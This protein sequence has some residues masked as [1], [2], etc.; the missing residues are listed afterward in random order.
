MKISKLS[1]LDRCKIFKDKGFYYKDN[2]VYSH[3]NTPIK[4]RDLVIR[5]KKDKISIYKHYFIWYYIHGNLPSEKL[6]HIDGNLNNNVLENLKVEKFSIHYYKK[7]KYSSKDG[8]RKYSKTTHINITELTKSI[9]IS[10]GKGYLI[11]EAITSII[12]L[13]DNLIRK[14]YHHNY[15]DCYDCKMEGLYHMLKGWK[16]FDYNKYDNAFTYLTELCKRGMAKQMNVLRDIDPYEKIR[17]R[18]ISL[19][20]WSE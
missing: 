9:I 17:P 6:V 12:K 10:Q 18:K 15:D 8:I 4:N 5:A 2:Q 3:R 11:P 16:N 14:F 7:Q 13:N 20:N 19:S 1:L